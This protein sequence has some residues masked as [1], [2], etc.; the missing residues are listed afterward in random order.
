[1]WDGRAACHVAE[2]EWRASEPPGNRAG[3]RRGPGAGGRRVL[4]GRRRTRASIA[5]R[6]GA[7]PGARLQD[8]RAPA[9]PEEGDRPGRRRRLVRAAARPRDRPGRPERQ[10]Q[11]HHRPDDHRA[12]SGPTAATIM[13]GDDARR[14]ARRRARCTTTAATCRCL[15]GPVLRAQPGAQPRLLA[16]APAGATTKELSGAEARK[17][18]MEL[19]E[20]VGLSPP[21][22]F[23]NKIPAPA[24]RRPA[25][26][27]R[28]RPRPGARPGHHHR[29]RADLDARRVDPRRDPAAARQA[30]ARAATSPSSTSPTTC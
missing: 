19:L 5:R 28:D 16:D 2:M 1:M 20:T 14:Q 9:G 18:A 21:E 13:F 27:R 8:V 30:R 6:G 24:L 25:P 15:P 10:R 22:Q 3:R 11:V 7:A 29:R 4:R 26:A 23:M 12:S 17:R